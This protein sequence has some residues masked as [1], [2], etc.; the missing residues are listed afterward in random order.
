MPEKI[1]FYALDPQQKIM[2]LE[3]V[4]GRGKCTDVSSGM[5]GEIFIFDQGASVV[6]RYI[7]AKVPRLL[8]GVVQVDIA[9][10]FLSEMKRQ[11]SFYH[12]AFV[13]WAFDFNS[14]LGVPVALFRYWGSDLE[15]L[16]RAGN[17]SV[18]EKLS[19]MIYM[20]EGLRHCYAK[21]LI[22]H[23]DLK[24]QNIFLR[25]IRPDFRG[26]PEFDVYKFPMIADFGLS[27]AFLDSGVYEGSRP[28]MAPE[29]WQRTELSQATD[30]FALGVIF[31]QLLTGGLHPIGIN[32]ADFWP[33]PKPGNS[34]KWTKSDVWKKWACEGAKIEK[35]DVGDQIYPQVISL[36]RQ[37]LS[38]DARD[39]PD[40]MAV[41]CELLLLLER[42]HH[43]S[44][45]QVELLIEYFRNQTSHDP[46]ETAWPYLANRWKCFEAEFGGR[47]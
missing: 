16:I 27:N 1:N 2:M 40:I 25:D 29:Q 43:E 11:L 35:T 7:C 5:C 21:G 9:Q 3:M 13:H 34:K 31:Y 37:M 23:Q 10:R 41:A 18:V 4:V 22:A 33:N 32:L 19:V 15:K 28:Y 44:H 39:R 30:I 46:L 38:S 42:I 8:D 17:S 26:L 14:I 12:H 45:D 20:L 6:P 24:P 36:I 47:A